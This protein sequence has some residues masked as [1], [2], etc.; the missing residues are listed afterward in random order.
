MSHSLWVRG[1][2]FLI[3]THTPNSIAVALFVSAWIEIDEEINI[4][5][6]MEV[7]LFVSAWIEIFDNVNSQA[8]AIVA[9]FVS[10]WIEI[11]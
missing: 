2:K 10:A 4:G 6:L 5:A 7:A 9:L 3:M 8:R 1:L 11:W